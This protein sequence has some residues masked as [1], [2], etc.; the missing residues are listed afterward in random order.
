M[1]GM[2]SAAVAKAVQIA[3][4]LEN[5]DVFASAKYA[6]MVP[7]QRRVALIQPYVPPK[8]GRMRGGDTADL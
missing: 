8:R 2:T 5:A 1:F 6:D 3:A 7:E 4:G